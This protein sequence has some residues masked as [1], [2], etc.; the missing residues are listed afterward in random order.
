MGPLVSA[1]PDELQRASGNSPDP[2]HRYHYRFVAARLG[3]EAAELMPD[4]DAATASVLCT[5]GSWIK[6]L[7]NQEADRFYKALVR[8]CG[9]TALGAEADRLRWFPKEPDATK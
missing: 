6:T 8:R 9:K 2:D 5:A 7:D 4:Q 3:W 1:D